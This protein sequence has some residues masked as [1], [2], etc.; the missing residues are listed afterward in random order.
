MIIASHAQQVFGDISAC[1]NVL[2]TV[3]KLAVTRYRVIVLIVK[4]VGMDYNV[5]RSVIVVKMLNATYA[6]VVQVAKM[7]IFKKFII[8]SRTVYYVYHFVKNAATTHSVPSVTRDITFIN[9]Q[10]QL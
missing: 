9:I 8:M 2:A 3:M 10:L 4:L 5:N 1:T 6:T 7:D